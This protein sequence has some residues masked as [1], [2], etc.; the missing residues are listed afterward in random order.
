MRNAPG[1]SGLTTSA[2]G[3]GADTESVPT[4]DTCVN[5]ALTAGPPSLQDRPSG[6]AVLPGSAA[7]ANGT[8]GAGSGSTLWN[9]ISGLLR[10]VG[11][12]YT[13]CW[14]GGEGADAVECC[15]DVE[16]GGGPGNGG[17][18]QMDLSGSFWAAVLY[19]T[20]GVSSLGALL[21]AAPAEGGPV[22]L[23]DASPLMES[24]LL[25]RF[26]ALERLAES[27]PLRAASARAP[28]A[29]SFAAVFCFRKASSFAG[30][31]S[32]STGNLWGYLRAGSSSGLW[33]E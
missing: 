30:R 4:P 12:G 24:S 11:F 10:S 26:G 23:A 27:V 29:P 32:G 28:F 3:Q 15:N 7:Y 2:L 31:G 1:L 17:G 33:G 14:S 19:W 21:F 22:A 6:K 16:E 20:A 18:S 13:V 9:L 25:L 8:T 5:V